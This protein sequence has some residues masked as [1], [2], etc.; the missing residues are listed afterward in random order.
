MPTQI[1][2]PALSPTMTEGNL[3]KWLKREGDAVAAGDVLAEIETDKATMEIEAV[4]D[5]ILGRILVPEG[6]EGIAVNAPIALLLAEGE[7]RAALDQAAP[8]ASA[9][10][11]RPAP[12]PARVSGGGQRRHAGR[13]GRGRAR[14]PGRHRHGQ[15]D[16]ARGAARRDGRG[17]AAR[18]RGVPDR[19]GGRRVPGRLQGEPGVARRVRRPPG[20]RHADH[21]AR[22]RGLRRRRR[23]RGPEADRRVHDLELRHAGDRPHHQLGGQDPLHGGR[24]ARLP[25]RVPRAQWRRRPGRRPAQP[26]VQQPGTATARA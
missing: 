7:D 1:L 3:A 22:L 9:P 6:A 4:D 17:D 13:A 14:D 8:A 23:L 15:A 26:G 5:G 19:R 18:S 21:R 16:R 10:A 12:A 24:R 11:V 25:D 20:D 2:M